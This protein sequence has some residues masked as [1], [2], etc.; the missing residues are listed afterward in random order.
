MLNG[1]LTAAAAKAKVAALVLAAFAIGTAAV[2]GP[3]SILPVADE[4]TVTTPAEGTDT[5]ETG[6][7]VVEGTE[8][9]E[10]TETTETPEATPATAAPCPADVKN[11]GAYVS[12][13]AKDPATRGKGHG[14]AVSAAAKSDCGKKAGAETAEGETADDAVR[15]P[16]EK[17]VK[18]AKKAPKTKKSPK[19]KKPQG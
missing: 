11:H 19:G 8:T 18:K 1:L 2:A 3:V 9:V 13:V 7:T 15:T 5:T 12:S 17:K 10:T 6:T 4:T 14:K 16:H